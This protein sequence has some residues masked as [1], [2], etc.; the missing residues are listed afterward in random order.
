MLEN[1]VGVAK[2]S[3]HAK[4]GKLSEMEESGAGRVLLC[5]VFEFSQVWS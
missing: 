2:T 3:N 1:D 4:K 5:S